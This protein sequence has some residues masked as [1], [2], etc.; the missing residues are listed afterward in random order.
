MHKE[1]PEKSIDFIRSI[2]EGGLVSLHT[3]QTW[4]DNDQYVTMDF[5]RFDN[6]GKIVEHCDNIQKIPKTSKNNNT[7]Y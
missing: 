6:N 4:P 1:S 7:M 3:Y 5:F 2:A